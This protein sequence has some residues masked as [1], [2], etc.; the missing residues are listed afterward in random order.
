MREV[1][2]QKPDPKVVPIDEIALDKYYGVDMGGGRLFITRETF[3]KGNFTVRSTRNLTNANGYSG[4]SNPYLD[5]LIRM[6][7]VN[8]YK[9]YE[10]D[11]FDD[12]ALWL[13]KK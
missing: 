8:D 12:L 6:L 2:V 9:V 3:D 11:S 1:I 5:G 13:R 10:F 7:V 4:Y